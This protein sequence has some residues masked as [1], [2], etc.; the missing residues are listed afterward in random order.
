[1][2]LNTGQWVVV[3]IAGVLILGFILGYYSN[4]Q[5]AEKMFSWL[6]L[7]LAT[8]G[9]VSR[10]A[11]LP[12]MVTG[13]RMEVKQAASPF[14]SVEAVYLLAPRENL[15]F[16]FFS[17]LQGRSDQV[18]IWINYQSKPNQTIEV[19]RK[20]DGQFA[21]RLHSTEKP[22]LALQESIGNLQ[23]AIEQQA[24]SSVTGKVLAFVQQNRQSI[25]RLALRPEKPHLF[26]RINSHLAGFGTSAELF[27]ELALLGE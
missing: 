14:K 17:L 12:G 21:K 24:D 9:E 13:G 22:P 23:V 19:A 8:L 1:M 7:G 25:V 11:K 3:I 20:G 6:H 18:I 16:W 4:R 5:K 15:I 26:L 27:K 2:V 10:G